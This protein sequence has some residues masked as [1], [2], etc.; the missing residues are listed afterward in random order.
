MNISFNI[1]YLKRNKRNLIRLNYI[2]GLTIRNR[3]EV[4]CCVKITIEFDFEFK[5]DFLLVII[6]D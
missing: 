3:F 1:G 5:F 2:K 6:I 4:S